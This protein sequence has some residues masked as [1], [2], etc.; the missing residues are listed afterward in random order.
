MK[1]DSRI[2]TEAQEMAREPHFKYLMLGL[3]CAAVVPTIYA[4][5][6]FL[7]H[8]QQSELNEQMNRLPKKESNAPQIERPSMIDD[9]MTYELFSFLA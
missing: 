7:P 9:E 2:Y 6:Y 4:R 5:R 1:L 3:V 8:V